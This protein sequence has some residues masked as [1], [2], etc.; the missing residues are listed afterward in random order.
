MKT[1]FFFMG[2]IGGRMYLGGLLINSSGQYLTCIR[3]NFNQV[4]DTVKHL[5]TETIGGHIIGTYTAYGYFNFKLCTY[6]SGA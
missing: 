2:E 6:P 1:M 5:T 4:N 3:K